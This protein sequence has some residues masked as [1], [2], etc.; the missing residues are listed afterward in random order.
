M[1]LLSDGWARLRD[2]LYVLTLCA[3][4][5][6]LAAM[7]S[8]DSVPPDLMDDFAA[9]AG[10]RP[11]VSPLGLHWQFFAAPLCRELGVATA[12]RVL[13]IA[14]H[15]AL[16]L[17]GMIAYAIFA[18]SVPAAFR[19]GERLAA[20]WRAAVRF[21]LLQGVVLLCCSDPVWSAFRWFSPYALQIL[22][23]ASATFLFLLHIRTNS[24]LPLFMTF[25][26][27]GFL[28]SDTP[29]GAL[30]TLAAA[31]SLRIRTY[32]R[33]AGVAPEPEE[34]PLADALMCL[35]LTIAFGIG[36]A[37]GAYLEKLAF[38]SLGGFEAWG[39]TWGDYAF[40]MPVV[41]VKKALSMCS[42]QGLGMF[43]LVVGPAVAV[44]IGL[45]RRA[46]DEETHLSY[47]CGALFA[48]FGLV[49]LTQLMGFPR[50]WFWT[51]DASHAT[52]R[53]GVLKT[54]AVFLCTLSVIWALAAFMTEFYLRNFRRIET[55]RFPDAAVET[56]GPEALQRIQ[57]LRRVMRICFLA[58]PFL[59]LSCV[60]PF[61]L[62]RLERAMLEVVADAAV[63]TA[64]ECQGAQYLFTDGGLDAAVELAAAKE[65]Q[66]LHALSLMGGAT[67]RREIFLRT[68]GVENPEDRALLESGAADAL[69]LWLRTRP[70]KAGE[71]A[72]QI[73]FELWRKDGRPM[74][75][76]SGLVARPEGFTEAEAE[77]GAVVGRTLAKRVLDLYA[78]DKPDV[79]PDR[80]LHDA[81]LFVQWRL[82]VL[83]RHRANAYD[84]RG[85]RELAMEETTLADGLDRKNAAL[86]RI[87]S[88]MAWTSHKKLERLTPQE[89]LKI[90]LARA[91]F[92]LARSFALQVLEFAPEDP[93]AN[94]AV[95]MDYFIQGQYSRAESYLS[96][97]LV[98]RPNDPAVLNN[99][100]QCR[101]RQGDFEGAMPYARQAL[102]AMPNS[103]EIKRTIERIKAGLGKKE[104]Q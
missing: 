80:A 40:E 20:W 94:F 39:W 48:V 5:A 88:T 91:D 72:I 12:G 63:E 15:V 56:G 8:F 64:R 9:A 101:L 89:G 82:A 87:R 41:Y 75:T 60:L 36:F 50:L 69:R 98:S 44:E 26:L 30:L 76:C 19:R 43:I 16:A 29:I 65:G 28:A 83:A 73:G 37:A 10:I 49:A 95:G 45:L 42:L 84:G 71:Y 104:D 18:M 13:C 67:D 32:M 100:A 27:S 68:R 61:R 70:D 23:A 25:A 99:M 17:L 38:E 11:P 6:G 103:A 24:R 53:D 57:S 92:S 54:F 34:N 55:L 31:T 93:S 1:T 78:S 58:E 4:V 85:E 51:W 2:R 79:I 96:R 33:I 97:C 86:A 62:Q 46:T 77:R 66:Q 21:V 47:N 22:V 35:R 90:G 102:E 59:V 3:A 14:G 52:V 7:W 74:P 81:F